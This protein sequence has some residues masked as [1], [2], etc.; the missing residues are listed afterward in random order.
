MVHLSYATAI[1]KMGSALERA[2][3]PRAYS[4]EVAEMIVEGEVKEGIGFYLARS[5]LEKIRKAKPEHPRV[6]YETPVSAVVWGGNHLGEYAALFSLRVGLQKARDTGLGAIGVTNFHSFSLLSSISERAA[7]AG[8]VCL[9]FCNTPSVAVPFNGVER[10]LGTNPLA[11]SVP[12]SPAPFT[13]DMATTNVILTEVRMAAEE[14]RPLREG[15]AVDRDGRP[16]TDPREALEGAL[17]TF[18]GYKGSGLSIMMSILAGPLLGM[19]SSFT[20][21]T[22]RGMFM[23]LI[24]PE[25]VRADGG[26][27]EDVESALGTFKE[28]GSPEFRLPG[29]GSREKMEAAYRDGIEVPDDYAELLLG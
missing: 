19:K 6:T 25:V 27:A 26:L 17:T 14:A 1:E 28:R 7:R 15:V 3:V 21:S 12:C 8:H 9:L 5:S 10:S 18:G 22:E 29:E 23:L 2:G 20:T 11:I 24:R 13:L 4:S 16:T